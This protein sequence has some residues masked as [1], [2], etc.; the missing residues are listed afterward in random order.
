MH[1]RLQLLGRPEL[2]GDG[3]RIRLTSRKGQALLFYLAVNPGQVF[4]RTYLS[5][6]LWCDS[7]GESARRSFNT[8]L[9]RFRDEMPVWPIAVQG[10]DLTWEPAAGVAVDVLEFVRYVPPGLLEG[11]SPAAT[12]ATATGASPTG[13]PR[14]PQRAAS[15]SRSAL[16]S[17]VALWRG[18]FCDGFVC[19]SDAY[20]EWLEQER[21]LWESRVLAVLEK[22]VELEAA[23]ARWS[24]VLELCRKALAVDGFRESFHRWTLTAHWG[25]GERTLAVA[26]YQQLARMLDRELGVAPEPATV[27]LFEGLSK[28]A[29]GDPLEISSATGSPAA[30]AT[31]AGVPAKGA[32]AH[33]VPQVPVGIGWRGAGNRTPFVGRKGLVA[34]ILQALESC[35]EGRSVF[36]LIHGEAGIGKSRLV[37][38]LLSEI[39]AQ[40]T[41]QASG[42]LRV[43]SLVMGRCSPYG[44]DLPYA[45]LVEG[46][47]RVLESV[48][49]GG[50]GLPDAVWQDL[51]L[52]VPGIVER[53]PLPSTGRARGSPTERLRLFQAVSRLLRALPRP[54]A[55][56]VEDLHWVDTE[57]LAALVYLATV[58]PDEG[59]GVAIIA[60]SRSADP[61]PEF[62]E[63]AAQAEREGNWVRIDLG[64]LSK[65]ESRDLIASTWDAVEPDVAG[66]IHDQAAGNPLHI[67]EIARY[68]REG[69]CLETT[70]PGEDPEA[71]FPVPPAVGR[72]VS[73]RMAGLDQQARRLLHTA[74]IFPNGVEFETLLHTGGFVED[75]ALKAYE[76]LVAADFF[77]PSHGHGITFAHDIVRRA[78]ADTLSPPRRAAM[79]RR[80]YGALTR[81]L[82]AGGTPVSAEDLAYHARAGELWREAVHW[83]QEAARAAERLFAYRAACRQLDRTLEALERLPAGPERAG[84]ER[85]VRAWRL[86][87]EYWFNPEQVEPQFD[88][89]L[90]SP[91]GGEEPAEEIPDVLLARAEVLFM[92]GKADAAEPL[93]ERALQLAGERDSVIRG[94]AIGGLGAVRL[95]RGDFREA[96]D[97][98]EQAKSL[99]ES[100]GRRFPGQSATLALASASALSG[101]FE[102]F[103]RC[104]AE[105]EQEPGDPGHT[106]KLH[107]NL[108]LVAYLQER[109][110]DAVREAALGMECARAADHHY[111]EYFCSIWLGAARLELGE[112]GR[113]LADF[114]AC[115]ALAAKAHTINLVDCVHAYKAM[116][117]VKHG[118][119]ADAAEVARAG[120][121]LA[122]SNG[123]KLGGALCTEALGH[124][125][126][127]KGETDAATRL[128]SEA[129]RRLKA[130]G[131]RPFHTFAL[132]RL[133]AALASRLGTQH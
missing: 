53:V 98:L 133:P 85:R 46:I 1:Y 95:I 30:R 47:N 124:V 7:P 102:R 128:L 2:L 13:S 71:P 10:N 117:L 120:L 109:S 54:V 94:F 78:V 48:D 72:A 66:R 132:R 82:E 40:A 111:N 35:S 61:S 27:Q 3:R 6:L 108:A 15:L 97:L 16:R 100:A 41:S 36:V 86:R 57:T 107:G 121:E 79:H 69:G 130:I 129:L 115:F 34:R 131:A 83:G 8:M 75:E 17:A 125:A 20:E 25:R 77:R 114:D 112:I 123:Y 87:L 81:A 122:T 118:R 110:K 11:A 106:A 101:D 62:V 4:S 33:S 44:E 60:T 104:L 99:V 42:G 119:P 93:L 12:L 31:T 58:Q 73:G 116:A 89:A 37:D 67:L 5:H 70:K 113:A 64:P 32:P 38:E 76:V 55:V 23:E 90:A 49:P 105:I 21:S 39:R 63:F 96:V 52:V 19:E 88:G 68:L 84:T 56:I 80:A 126:L 74:S 9:T 92:Q 28:G 24:D 50:L 26:H 51:A 22:L 45:P 65:E 59:G 43:G 127:A 103:A 91:V 18:A 14:T 29:A